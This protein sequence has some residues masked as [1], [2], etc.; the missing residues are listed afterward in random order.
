M[1]SITLALA[2][3]AAAALPT[4]TATAAPTV[5]GVFNLPGTPHHL[6]LGPDGNVWIALDGV[7]DDVAEVRPDGT[8]TAFQTTDITSPNG[9]VA[10][11]DGNLW[12]TQSGGV[13]RFSPS[14]PTRTTA[15]PIADIT[16]PRGI[17]VGPDGKLWTGSGD[18]VVQIGT[19]GSAR[20]FTVTGMAA[21]G[22]A[23]GG[24]GQLY[25]ADFGNRRVVGITPDGTPTFYPL[26]DAPQEVV[27]GPPGQIVATVPSNLIARFTP[28]S[29]TV[30]NT[31]VTGN[32]PFGAVFAPDGAY[33]IAAFARDGLI[34]M[35][36]DGAVTTLAGF[37][38]LSG[39]RYLTV[40]AG[41]T[42]WVGL[43]LSSQVARVTGVV[44]PTT[45]GSGGGGGT[46]P[47]PVDT[48]APAITHVSLPARLRVGR[49]GTLRLTLDE[50][51]TVRVR[52]DRRLPGRRSANGHCV[53]PRR[54]ARHGKRCTRFTRIG[55]Q[56]RSAVAG[57]N[58]LKVGGKLGRRTIPVGTYRLTITATDAAG[59]ASAPIRRTLK[60]VARRRVARRR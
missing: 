24:D 48:Q 33:W 39:P 21:R 46:T 2:A 17:V 14:D 41:G 25:V 6:T 60:V 16:D 56:T 15:F 10:G 18:K 37:P 58:A 35:T 34:R 3:L 12:V 42:L 32:D 28:P 30:Q 11:P 26:D 57:A 53:K 1:R 44:A 43:E 8:V 36:P 54:H 23:A 52:F 13:V 45:G 49:S 4:A 27:A 19:D 20:S 55:T 38:R 51:A 9:I 31:T 59:N 29:T 47:P 22:I 40:G 7:T 5:D 50:A